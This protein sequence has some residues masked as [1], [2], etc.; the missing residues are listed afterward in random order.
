[1]PTPTPRNPIRPARGNYS[2]LTAN[3]QNLY[4][5]ELA[6]AIDQ[7]RLYM[8]ENGTLVAVG[9]A[10]P[11]SDPLNYNIQNAVAGESLNYNGAEWVNGGVQ[12]GG[13]F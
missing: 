4:D 9:G 2:D 10:N 11:A 3:I 13:N 1:M 7:D 12:D 6:Y 5:G 8:N